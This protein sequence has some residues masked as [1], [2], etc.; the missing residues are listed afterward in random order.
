MGG[1]RLDVIDQIAKAPDEKITGNGPM[2]H[3]Y[4][5]ELSRETFQKGDLVT[6]GE[7][8]GASPELAKLYSCPDGSEFSMVFQFE[9]IEQAGREAEMG[10]GTVAV[11][12]AEGGFEPLASQPLWL[13]LEQLVLG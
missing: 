2:L 4:I 11:F 5:R 1:F 10:F 3:T 8:W 13:R 9:H 7:A 12:E 6:V